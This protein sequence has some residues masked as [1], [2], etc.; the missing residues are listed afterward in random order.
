MPGTGHGNACHLEPFFDAGAALERV[1]RIYAAAAQRVQQRLR[2]FLTDDAGELPVSEVCYPYVGLE[3]GPDDIPADVYLSW[4]IVRQPG[5]YGTTVTRP[6]LFREYLRCQFDALLRHHRGPLLV[7]VSDRPVALPFIAEDAVID[8][9]PDAAA[10]LKRRFPPPD[11]ARIDDTIPNGTFRPGPG[12]PMPLALFNA[13]R[14]DL[15]LNRLRHYTGTR[16]EHFQSFVLFTNYQRYVSEFIA[17]GRAA[18]QRGDGYVAFVEPGDVVLR[19]G[20]DGAVATHGE[21]PT[22]LPQMPAYHAVRED[23]MGITLVNIGVGPTNAKTLTDHLAVLRP[24]CWLMLGHCGG[25]RRSQTLGDYVLAHAYVREDHVLDQDLPPWV[26]LPAIAEVQ[27][28]LEQAVGRC[29]GLTGQALKR[30]MRTGTVATTANR[31]WELRFHEL[32]TRFSQ[33]RA[34]AV[35]MESATIAGNGFRLRIPYG[36]LLCVSDKPLHGELKLRNMANAFYDAS[37]AQHLNIGL[38]T[39]RILREGGVD[40][41]HS[42]KLRS[43]DEPPFM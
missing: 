36:T 4:G 28:A 35:D 24:H 38:E 37:V 32:H 8:V 3:V 27:I 1:E 33:S 43:F 41:L 13:E 40:V 5:V 22:H 9:G 17:R 20:R 29:T 39:V 14:V 31:N 23:G 2:R 30:R 42:R 25:L 6:D 18:V 11:I 10:R 15:S 26:P 34:V 12:Q 19:P 21:P 16:P 7:G